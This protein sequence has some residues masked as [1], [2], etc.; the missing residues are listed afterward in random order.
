MIFYI[1]EKKF[2]KEEKFLHLSQTFF[3]ADLLIFLVAH[4]CQQEEGA[5]ASIE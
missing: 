1:S 3:A 4:L 5:F 2:L